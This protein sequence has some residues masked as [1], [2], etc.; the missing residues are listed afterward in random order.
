MM[1]VTARR[2]CAMLAVPI[3]AALTSGCFVAAVSVEE[4]PRAICQTLDEAMFEAS[5]EDTEATLRGYADLLDVF[6][7][8][9]E[10]G[11]PGVC[12]PWLRGQ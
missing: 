7:G 9:P 3:L 1:S 2:L 8:R 4:T 11:L 12:S 5:A 10:D 6:Y